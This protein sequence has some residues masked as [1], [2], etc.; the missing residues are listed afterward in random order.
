MVVISWP[1]LWVVYT[2]VRGEL[3]VSP[4]TGDGWWYPYPFL[5]PHVQGGYL[6]VAFYVAGIAAAFT[7][8]AWGVVAVGRRRDIAPAAVPSTTEATP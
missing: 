3:V 2:L 8:V 5:N 4:L 1:I 6:V 7:L